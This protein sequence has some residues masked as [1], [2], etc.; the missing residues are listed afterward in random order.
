MNG[1]V[2]YIAS[3]LLLGA[4][5]GQLQAQ[6]GKI[7][8]RTGNKEYEA[9]KYAEAEASYRTALDENGNSYEGSFNLGDAA[10]KQEKYDDAINQ[11]ELL[12]KK[13]GTKEQIASAYHNL[14]NAY[15][16]KKE[17][18]KGVEA[19]KQA[20]RNNPSDMDTKY[21][22]AYAQMQLKQQQEQQKKEEKNKDKEENEDKKDEE[23]KD[24]EK[25]DDKE[26]K[27]KEKDEK[28]QDEK[29]DENKEDQEKDQ[30]KKD[31]NKDKSKEEN[32]DQQPQK[33]PRPNELTQEEAKKMLEALRQK[34]LEVQNKLQKKRL[35][36]TKVKSDKDW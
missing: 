13:A 10:Y 18:E 7:H 28:D 19:Y 5:M 4:C 36:S 16:K 3:V 11:F 9:G 30:K 26:E 22:L 29:K 21:N 17:Y 35:K 14:G 23:K 1:L 20:L 27:D 6:E 12:S 2:K 24:E 32:K 34:E 8:I 33:K 31:E 25:K 15:L